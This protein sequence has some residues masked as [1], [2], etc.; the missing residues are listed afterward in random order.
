MGDPAL[1]RM[2]GAQRRHRLA[3]LGGG[4]R[5]AGQVVIGPRLCPRL[6]RQGKRQHEGGVEQEGELSSNHAGTMAK[7]WPPILKE[8]A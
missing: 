1:Q 3:D 4:E 8:S 7:D 6:R 2:V 5:P